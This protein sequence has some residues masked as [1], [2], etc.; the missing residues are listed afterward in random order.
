LS[1]LRTGIGRYRIDRVL[2]RGGMALVYLG[3][4]T[5]LGRPVAIKLLADNLATD[6]SFRARFMREARMAAGLSHIN[7]VHVYDV[8]QDADQRPYIVMEYVDGESLAETVAREGR[9]PPARVHEI[10]LDCCRG[11]QHAH[12]AGLVHRDIKPHNLLADRAGLVKIADFG[13]ARSLGETQLTM[14]GS[15]LG[16]ARYLSPEQAA[17]RPVTPVADIYSLGVTLY[18]LLTGRTPHQ[19]DS[20]AELVQ[21]RAL[22]PPP[23][24]ELAPGVPEAFE[25]AV[26]S[27]LDDD[28]E[29]RPRSATALALALGAADSTAA[30]RVIAGPAVDRTLVM[31]PGPAASGPAHVPSA[32]RQLFAGDRR[33][34][35]MGLAIGLL[36]VLVVVI[37]LAT[38][39]G[40]AKSKPPAAHQP[41]VA[42][43]PDGA[44]PADDAHNLA[45]WIRAHTR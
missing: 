44:T 9:I 24:A 12:A 37:A 5:E 13:V 36:I 15:V 6:E 39:G 3:L 16:S 20:L 41:T 22:P 28:P 32:R 17:G 21:Q 18:E 34:R 29:R 33:V 4:D 35:A 23:I 25:T 2:G 7:I 26:T 42:A 45:A 10:A 27:C 19:G 11:L 43:V 40:G 30:T 38:G 31:D 14:V 1:T 8:G